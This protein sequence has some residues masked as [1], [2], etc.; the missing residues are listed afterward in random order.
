MQRPLSVRAVGILLVAAHLLLASGVAAVFVNAPRFRANGEWLFAAML[1]TSISQAGL[2][3]LWSGLANVP[4]LRR[5]LAAVGGGILIWT[6][7]V[8]ALRMTRPSSDDSI[9]L[10]MAAVF[11][12]V[13]LVG[14]GMFAATLKWRGY[15]IERPGPDD[16]GRNRHVQFSLAH[17]FA[18]TL[19]AAILFALVR[20]LRDLPPPENPL[21]ILRVFLIAAF[22]AL[23]F[24]L[25]TQVCLWASL[26]TGRLIT[27]LAAV[28]L[29]TAVATGIYGFAVGGRQD[30]Y[31]ICIEMMSIYSVLVTGSLLV[32]RRLG[33]RLLRAVQPTASL[34]EP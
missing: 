4:I 10:I 34:D 27:R 11:T 24:V 29:S 9:D 30:D 19:I 31:L 8:I 6:L 1:G 22:N 26:S 33:Y 7:F 3:G 17:L 2:V 20:G 23:V 21:A 16:K 14:V 25:H 18:I 5:L 28:L 13:P 12:L 32:W 15:R